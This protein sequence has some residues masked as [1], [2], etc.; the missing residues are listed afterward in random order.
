MAGGTLFGIGMVIAGGCGA[1][2]I[3]RAGEG[4]VKLWI[5][6][7]FF[8]AGASMMRRLLVSTELIGHLGFASFLPN[9]LVGRT[10]SGW[11]WR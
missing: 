3:W 9:L 4:H 2:S 5:A 6:L 8:A 1:G 7:F 10:R 11:L